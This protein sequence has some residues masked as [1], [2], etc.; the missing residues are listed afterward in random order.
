ML[1]PTISIPNIG[2]IVSA[3][4]FNVTQKIRKVDV[5]I[6]TK[7]EVLSFA[8]PDWYIAF[9][10]NL[11]TNR[12]ESMVY[13]YDPEESYDEANGYPIGFGG[14]SEENFTDEQW[15]VIA[16]QYPNLQPNN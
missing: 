3:T 12:I 11:K 5:K 14:A 13:F 4:N 9:G 10:Q 1:H 2:D 16:A 8:M 6:L 7:F 15:D